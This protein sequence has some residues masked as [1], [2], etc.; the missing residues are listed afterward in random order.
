MTGQYDKAR[1]TRTATSGTNKAA[2]RRLVRSKETTAVRPC[3]YCLRSRVKQ[4]EGVPDDRRSIGI[5]SIP[6]NNISLSMEALDGD[7]NKGQ[8]SE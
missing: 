4:P 1:E 5:E 6:Q 8:R 7:P 3:P 2:E